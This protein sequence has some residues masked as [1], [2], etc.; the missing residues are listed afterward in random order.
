[1]KEYK[2]T[3]KYSFYSSGKYPCRNCGERKPGCHDYCKGYQEAKKED[4]ELRK[5]IEPQIIKGQD[6][7]GY[8]ITKELRK[9]KGT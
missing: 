4:E 6:V 7:S 1:M 5:K 2:G 9:R 3:N 8:Y